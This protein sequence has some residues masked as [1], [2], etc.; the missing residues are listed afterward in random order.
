MITAVAWVQSLAQNLLHAM[1]MAKKQNKTKQNK[2]KKKQSLTYQENSFLSFCLFVFVFCH[3]SSR[4]K[5]M[6]WGL[7][8]NCSCNLHHSCSNTRSSMCYSCST[9]ELPEKQF[10]CLLIFAFSGPHLSHMKVPRLGVES[11]LQLPA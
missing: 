7:S 9:T 10:F 1:R 3:T 5:F 2:Q 8:P 11:E 6:G 4:W